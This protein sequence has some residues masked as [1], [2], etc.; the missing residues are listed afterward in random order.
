MSA[1]KEPN[2]FGGEENGVPY[3][4]GRVGRLE[5]Y[6]RLFDAS[7]EVRGEASPSYTNHPHRR[8]VPERIRELVPDARFVYLV[9][10]PVARA[11]SHFQHSQAVGRERRS[12][13]EALDELSTSSLS[14]AGI[15]RYATQLELY[16]Q[17]F[18]AERI[19]VV[20]HA[21]LR[22]DRVATLREIFAFLSVDPAF[23]CAEFERELYKT[24]ERRMYP[25]GYERLVGRTLKP[26]AQWVPPRLRRSLRRSVERVLWSPVQAPAVD[27]ELRV[28]LG[29]LY[30]GEAE[31]LRA[32][33][34]KRF[35]TWSV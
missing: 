15:S 30:A 28:R 7:F 23:Q 3:P 34:G 14:W 18:P 35:A 13:R 6:E 31:R 8:G 25:P 26:V 20:D 12:L 33:T 9:R 10:D 24:D 11:I 16:L 19:M 29:E 27:D 4:G 1:V 21:E 17:V 32:L 22:A 2:F 5:E